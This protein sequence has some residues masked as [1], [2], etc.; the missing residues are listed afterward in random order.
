MY[1]YIYLKL[2]RLESHHIICQALAV[3]ALPQNAP[4]SL[5]NLTHLIDEMWY[6]AGD[7]SVDMNWYSKRALLAAVYTS[8]EWYMTTDH[9]LEYSETFKFL[10]RRL[11][12]TAV[13]GK[14]SAQMRN[15]VDFGLRSI[16]GVL[17]SKGILK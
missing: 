11:Q 13:I 2:K 5:S 14:T 8:S 7:S 3:M 17:E 12:D 4:T 10:D 15:V 9:S 1:I 16:K 6:L